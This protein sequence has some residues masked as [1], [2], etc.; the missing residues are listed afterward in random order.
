MRINRRGKPRRG[1]VIVLAPVV[2]AVLG[3]ILALTTDVGQMVVWRARVQNGADA[4]AL[5]AIHTLVS[6]RLDGAEEAEARAAATTEAAAIAEANAAGAGMTIAFGTY[7]GGA[8][9][10]LD[11]GTAATAVLVTAFRNPDAPGGRLPL[12]FAPLVGVNACDVSGAAIC[13]VTADI[14]GILGG[15]SPFA[16]PEDRLVP[17]GGQ[18]VFYPGD[19]EV[20]DGLGG[21]MLVPGAWGLLNLDGGALGTD[22]LVDWIENGFEGTVR[23][24]PE[25]GYAWVNGTTGFRAALQNPMRAKIGDSLIVVIYDDVRGT[26]SN[27]N[28]RAVG[29]MRI[30]ITEVKLVGQGKHISCVVAEIGMFHDL[31][32]GLGTASPNILKIQL[33]H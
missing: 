4:A 16:V 31:I 27:T 33:V 22:E 13:E 30:T 21:V 32:A 26:G 19:S 6:E 12:I 3:G 25:T 11:D 24:D 17:P 28:F 1:Q 2:L 14:N 8:F 7:G 5:A 18:I 20:H 29:F 15:L 23:L 10:E 9:S